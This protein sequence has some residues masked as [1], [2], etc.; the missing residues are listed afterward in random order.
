[1][2]IHI[3]IILITCAISIIAFGSSALM[4]RCQLNSWA[5]VHHKEYYRIFTYGF[6]HGDWM[7]LI[8]NMF[9]LYSFGR[10][11]IYSFNNVFE[12]NNEI[13]FLLLYMSAIIVSTIYSV[14]KYRNNPNYNAVGASGAVSAIVYTTIFLN[15]YDLLYLWTIPIPGI[16][17]GIVYLV[18][19][20][21][22]AKRKVDNIGHDA[23]FW[24]AVYG[25]VFPCFYE[26]SLMIDF[27]KKLFFIG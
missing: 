1:M 3:I 11:T 22:M 20:W 24:G 13:R 10:A 19:S 21:I 5:V 23:H 26:P 27:V 7:H 4:L 9:V 12:G 16:V 18:Y 25:F 8:I 6:L 15:P 2:N 17:F 14:F